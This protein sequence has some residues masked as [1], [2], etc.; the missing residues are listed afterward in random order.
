[1]DNIIKFFSSLF[2]TDCTDYETRLA[3]IDE[4]LQQLRKQL[5][6][7]NNNIDSINIMQEMENKIALKNKL[8]TCRNDGKKRSKRK[9]SKKKR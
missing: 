3:N 7:E 9:R 4:K 5:N 2:T 8:K 6:E 1:M